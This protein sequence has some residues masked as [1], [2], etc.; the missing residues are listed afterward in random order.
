MSE[1][2]Q[3]PD[4]EITPATEK[5][6]TPTSEPPVP[7]KPV[8]KKPFRPGKDRSGPR[9]ERKPRSPTLT[10]PLQDLSTHGPNLRELDAELQDELNASLAG[11][12]EEAM[13]GGEPQKRGAKAEPQE[14]GRKKGK[15]VAIHG[16]DVFVDVPGGRSQGVIGLAQFE[17]RTPA[18]GE[19]VEVDI[20]GYDRQ[21]GLLLLTKLGAVQVV[22]WSS[23]APGLIVEARV[24]GTN[25][26]GLSV[27]VNG[28]RGFMPISQID[29]YRVEQPEQF[30]NQRLRCVVTEVK[31]EEK[32]LVVSRRAL[33]E[34]EREEQREKFWAELQEGQV[35]TG[36]VR[37]LQK[38]GAFVDLGGADGLI[39]MSELSWSR[40]ENAADVVKEGQSVQVKVMRVDRAAR[41]IG[42][43]LKQMLASP[44]DTLETRILP[45]S[46]VQGKVTRIMEFG[47]FVE[48]EPG[49]EGLIHIS[50]VAS[51]RVRRVRDFLTESQEVTVKILSV[52]K[53][54][55]RI[56]L[57]V[58]AA[59]EQIETPEEEAAAEAPAPEQKPRQRNYQLR[60]GVGGGAVEPE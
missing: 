4:S 2:E 13:L 43:S 5:P 48:L 26:G 49:V 25:K 35:R 33:L 21:N 31:P 42:L 6:P 41:R 57:S 53:E 20:E 15:V 36:V 30:V 1:N 22:D 27:E 23:V 37:S 3:K 44:W 54:N 39:P 11:F 58:K 28:I 32:N 55:R 7:R 8:E 51:Q 9:G 56:S 34:R 60:G 29:L 24:T 47:A 59:V 14:A 46:T 12:S 52:D 17:G 40:V 16:E 10:E 18:I 19:V 45:G 38:F 50:E